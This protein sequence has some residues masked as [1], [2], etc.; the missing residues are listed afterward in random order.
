MKSLNLVWICSPID[1]IALID[2]I[3][4]LSYHPSFHL[5]LPVLWTHIIFSASN[6]N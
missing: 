1:R 3:A 5:S 6:A 4:R 2:L